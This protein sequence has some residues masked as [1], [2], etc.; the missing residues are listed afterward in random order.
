MVTAIM[1][2]AFAGADAGGAGTGVA[3]VVVVV[4]TVTGAVELLVQW[5]FAFEI[6]CAR[7]GVRSKGEVTVSCFKLKS[8]DFR[9]G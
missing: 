1:L 8:I 6:A 2:C 4:V 9:L 3:V 5:L 7:G